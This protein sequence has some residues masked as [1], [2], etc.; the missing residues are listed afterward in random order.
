MLSLSGDFG[1]AR[2]VLV[3]QADASSAVLDSVTVCLLTSHI[4]PEASLRIAIEP[5]ETNGL[6]RLSQ[7]QTDKIQTTRKTK[8]KGPIG[9]LEANMMDAV[10]L[11]LAFHLGLSARSG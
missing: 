7:V 11:A 1:K 6:D 4:V 2:P 5:D 9:R 8:L 10:D 3:V